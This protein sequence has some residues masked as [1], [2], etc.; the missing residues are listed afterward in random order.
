[1]SLGKET[2]MFQL[3]TVGSFAIL[4]FNIYEKEETEVTEREEVS[5]S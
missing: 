4:S 3:V 5:S 1:M 2:V